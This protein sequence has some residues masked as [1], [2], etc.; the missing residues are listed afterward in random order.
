[1]AAI[2]CNVKNSNIKISSLVATHVN[3]VLVMN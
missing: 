1:M 3:A 2:T